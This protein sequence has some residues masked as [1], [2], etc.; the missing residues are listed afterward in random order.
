MNPATETP[1][2]ET[3]VDPRDV[4]RPVLRRK[5]WILLL[6]VVVTVATY[7]Y[8]E[9]KPKEYTAAAKLFS[10][11]SAVDQVLLGTDAATPS[12]QN[13]PQNLAALAATRETAIRVRARIGYAGT[14]EGLLRTLTATSSQDSDIVT[15]AAKAGKPA[16]AA[17]IANGFATELGK[18]I[19]AANRA[20]AS[21]AILA[22]ERD[23]AS[24]PRTDANAGTRTALQDRIRRLKVMEAIPPQQ[25]QIA[26][27]AVA[28]TSPSA[29]QPRRDAAFALVISLLLGVAAALMLER[30][31]RQVCE[32]ADELAEVFGAPLLGAVPQADLLGR[33]QDSASFAAFKES[34]R[35]LRT[36]IWLSGVGRPV[37]LLVVTSSEPVEGKSTIAAHLAI[38]YAEAG[39]R[40]SVVEADLRRPSL[41][42]FFEVERSPGLTEVIAGALP[43]EEARRTVSLSAVGSRDALGNGS[44]S[45]EDLSAS[46]IQLL[47]SGVTPPDPQALLS[48]PATTDI[49]NRL[50][51]ESDVV[52]IDTPPLL[53][54]SDAMPLISSAD[55]VLV[56]G[57]LG[58]TTHDSVKRL[59]QVLDRVE[60]SKV[61]GVVAN[62]VTG[63]GTGSGYGY[64][65]GYG[66]GGYGSHSVPTAKSS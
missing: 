8:Y 64:G 36:S 41:A 20:Q 12:S 22:A 58:R 55:A 46:Q 59:R 42:T 32:S 61:L 48:L 35:D 39:K 62:G 14:P 53:A 11:N 60:R 1:E 18:R 33:Q 25:T 9:R 15:L 4:L 19:A 38:A 29:P 3:R 52:I 26:E 10:G 57:R 44:A 31:S 54:V 56:V 37:K 5:W 23:L 45:S 24:Q 21:A 6:A 40:V 7:A 43:L 17:A 51:E 65:Y 2:T 66:D 47:T 34:L 30:F 16:L 49:L 27:M 28:P 13:Q 63:R 50:A